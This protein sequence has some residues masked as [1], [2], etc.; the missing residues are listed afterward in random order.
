MEGTGTETF[1]PE[2]TTSRAMFLT[3]LARLDG[4]DTTQGAW[5]DAAA[6][7]AS[8]A[9]ISD[10]RNLAGDLTWEQLAAMLYRYAQYRG[11]DLSA[12]GST[13][14]SGGTEAVSDDWAAAM[15]WALSAGI[16]TDGLSHPTG[17]LTR[18]QTADAL[19]RFVSA[20]G[21]GIGEA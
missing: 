3:A 17:S 18:A 15:E 12:S 8:E 9:G 7:W 19:M 6:R 14:P 21:T 2:A 11:Y 1:S 16:L 10:A 4:V 20:I 5:Y 13:E